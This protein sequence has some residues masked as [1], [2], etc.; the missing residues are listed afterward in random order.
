MG[1]VKNKVGRPRLVINETELQKELKKYINKEQTA[2]KTYSNLRIG[3]TS[4]YEIL[5]KELKMLL[6][7][8]KLK[9][10]LLKHY[11]NV[12]MQIAINGII[13]TTLFLENAKIIIDK[14][15]IMFSNGEYQNIIIDLQ[16]A[17]KI[18]II[19]KWHIL[20]KYKEIEI[21]IQQ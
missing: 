18:K 1:K 13:N 10:I 4:F 14:R 3:K 20:I 6:Q 16:N 17:G 8:S 2:V 15:K 7:Y 19:N 21:D 9:Y 5:K 12:N 11:R